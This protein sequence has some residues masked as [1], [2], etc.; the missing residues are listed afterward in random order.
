[1]PCLNKCRPKVFG[2]GNVNLYTVS[3]LKQCVYLSTC[4]PSVSLVCDCFNTLFAAAVWGSPDVTGRSYQE[5]KLFNRNHYEE[6]V[7]SSVIAWGTLLLRSNLFVFKVCCTSKGQTPLPFCS[8]LSTRRTV[9][10]S[11]KNGPVHVPSDWHV[12][13]TVQMKE[14]SGKFCL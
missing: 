6:H 9:Q 8:G 5:G 13:H 11:R 3:T 7:A 1:M 10:R 12:A 14:V 4:E 2:T